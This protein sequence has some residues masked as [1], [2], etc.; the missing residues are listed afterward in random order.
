MELMTNM[1]KQKCTES[2]GLR[3]CGEIGTNHIVRKWITGHIVSNEWYCDKHY[4]EQLDWDKEDDNIE[5]Q[6]KSPD[7]F[8]M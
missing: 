8:R 1:K 3:H 4:Q 7:L 2:T 6:F 5:Y